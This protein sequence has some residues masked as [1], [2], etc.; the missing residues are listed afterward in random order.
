MLIPIQ[1]SAKESLWQ[2]LEEDMVPSASAALLSGNKSSW[3]QVQ[4]MVLPT[5]TKDTNVCVAGGTKF[6][7]F[8]L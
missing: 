3:L 7:M 1:A 4:T 8:H 2:S 6:M 5:K